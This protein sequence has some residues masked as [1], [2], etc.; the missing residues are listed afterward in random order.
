MRRIT[1]YINGKEIIIITATIAINIFPLTTGLF[2]KSNVDLDISTFLF[3]TKGNKFLFSQHSQYRIYK[4]IN[5]M[6]ITES[7][8]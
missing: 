7:G 2:V 3:S 5:R 8:L 4:N 1:V 6:T